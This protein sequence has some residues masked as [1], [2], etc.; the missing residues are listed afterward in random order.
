MNAFDLYPI[1]I[2]SDRYTGIY[3][4]GLFLVF[5]LDLYEVPPDVSGEDAANWWNDYNLGKSD[6]KIGKGDTP[7]E[8]LNDLI[9][10][11]SGKDETIPLIDEESSDNYRKFQDDFERK[12]FYGR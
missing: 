11:L 7:D 12:M 8:A 6:I 4:K 5:N 2:I 1:T 10:Q 3:S 9:A